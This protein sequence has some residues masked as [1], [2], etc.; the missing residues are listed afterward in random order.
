MTVLRL[1]AGGTET[2]TKTKLEEETSNILND[3]TEATVSTEG[4]ISGQTPLR[5]TNDS[6]RKWRT[7]QGIDRDTEAVIPE[8]RRNFFFVKP[9]Q[10]NEVIKRQ[11]HNYFKNPAKFGLSKDATLED[12]IKK[13]DQ[14]NPQNKINF[15]KNKGIDIKKKL[16]DFGVSALKFL[17]PSVEASDLKLLGSPDQGEQRIRES[18]VAN[19]P[20]FIDCGLDDIFW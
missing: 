8:D 2:L 17:L 1:L 16:K 13:F 20:S 12:A 9:D 6:M 15:L 14:Q 11:W 7:I 5:I 19:K 3:L 18:L 4:L 10:V